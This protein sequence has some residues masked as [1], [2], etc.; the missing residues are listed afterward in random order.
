MIQALLFE[1]RRISTLRSTW[2]LGGIGISIV[3]GL[4]FL[5]TLSA[6]SFGDFAPRALT[7][8]VFV[9]Y[10]PLFLAFPLTISAQA[11]GHDYRHGTIRITL[12]SFPRRLPLYVM[13]IFVVLMSGALLTVLSVAAHTAI[14]M[15]R[16]SEVDLDSTG[17]TLT[18]LL[19]FNLLFIL[20]TT[21]I[22][23]ITRNMALGIVVPL[24]MMSFAEFAV[25]A[26]L[27]ADRPWI[28]ENLPAMNALNWVMT[29]VAMSGENRNTLIPLLVL[30]AILGVAASWRFLKRDA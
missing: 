4:T 17:Q 13:R 20:V 12:S 18:R 23:V 14:L 8:F 15:A 11:F 22:V 9:L 24:A 16:L 27:G 6:E 28:D 7:D 1:W 30:T 5:S 26:L 21:F 25:S 10:V 3:A 29:D 19:V 2:V